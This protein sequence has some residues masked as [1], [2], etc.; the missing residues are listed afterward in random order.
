MKDKMFGPSGLLC[1]SDES[2]VV[3]E[4]LAKVGD[5]WSILVIVTIARTENN[6]ARFSELQR[7]IEGISQR[8]LTTTLRNLERDG[9]LIR[10]VYPE[11]PP[12]VE[13]ELTDL[14]LSILV[15]MKSLV[16]WIGTNWAE[17][18]R[19]RNNFDNR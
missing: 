9:F 17:I 19:A 7:M 5:K 14:G 1:S 11:V 15:P 18:K 2:G 16:D 13:Y 10:T 6:K 12:K 3:R 4:F 8:M